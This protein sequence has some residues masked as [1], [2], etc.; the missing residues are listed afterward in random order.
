MGTI[1]ITIMYRNKHDSR[2][3]PGSRYKEMYRGTSVTT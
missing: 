2:I 3:N 1:L